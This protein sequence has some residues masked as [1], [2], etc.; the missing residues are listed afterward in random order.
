MFD[1]GLCGEHAIICFAVIFHMFLTKEAWLPQSGKTLAIWCTLYSLQIYILIWY[2]LAFEAWVH[3]LSIK[4]VGF[5]FIVQSRFSIGW[6]GCLLV[7]LFPCLPVYLLAL[8]SHGDQHSEMVICLH[9]WQLSGI[10]LV[11]DLIGIIAWNDA[12]HK[13]TLWIRDRVIA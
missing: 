12:G 10:V 6:D 13:L 11:W 9:M 4:L 8:V 1:A 3:S 2:S 5:R 7:G